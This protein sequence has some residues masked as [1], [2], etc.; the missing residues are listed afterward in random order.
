MEIHNL[1]NR[2][3]RAKARYLQFFLQYELFTSLLK[4]FVESDYY[5]TVGELE[6]EYQELKLDIQ[7]LEKKIEILNRLTPL[8]NDIDEEKIDEGIREQLLELEMK[9]EQYEQKF[10]KSQLFLE[11][12]SECSK[13]IKEAVQ[14]YRAICQRI[15]P[16]LYSLS[17]QE[18]QLF[19]VAQNSFKELKL[20][21]ISHIALFLESHEVKKVEENLWQEEITKL[22]VESSLLMSKLKDLKETFPFS[23][24]KNIHRAAWINEYVE[25]MEGEINS[26]SLQKEFL[27]ET[28]EEILFQLIDPVEEILH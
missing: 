2:Y 11:H 12:R 4:Q 14:G 22:N 19:K 16:T 20:D 10:E 7:F 21:V 25:R 17:S 26:L 6:I 28:V 24:S 27:E 1:S 8:E 23:E 9:L 3:Q 15:H 18:N 5:L 13:K